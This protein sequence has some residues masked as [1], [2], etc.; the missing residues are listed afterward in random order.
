MF[1]QPGNL[2]FF[3]VLALLGLGSLVLIWF[4]AHGPL[5]DRTALIG[6]V[7]SFLALVG[8]VAGCMYV[9]ATGNFITYE[10]QQVQFMLRL[11]WV[12]IGIVWLGA[13]VAVVDKIRRARPNR[14]E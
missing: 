6:V 1:G 13:V 10:S 9:L 14:T 5:F 2:E 7:L 3:L 8:G 4:S 11:D 12:A